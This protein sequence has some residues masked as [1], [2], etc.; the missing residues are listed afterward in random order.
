MVPAHSTRIS[1]R[2]RAIHDSPHRCARNWVSR[3]AAAATMRV[4]SAATALNRVVT[5]RRIGKG[6]ISG[7][8]V[9]D[10]EDCLSHCWATVRQAGA[11]DADRI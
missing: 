4:M 8:L 5:E 3:V 10:D 2:P 1:P 9:R 6:P 11:L 7:R